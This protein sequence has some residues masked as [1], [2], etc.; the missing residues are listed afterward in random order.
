MVGSHPY[1]RAILRPIFSF[2][3]AIKV[4]QFFKYTLVILIYEFEITEIMIQSMNPKITVM[5]Y[6]INPKS[7]KGISLGKVEGCVINNKG[8]QIYNKENSYKGFLSND[9]KHMT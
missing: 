2:R 9:V 8:I 7:E 5:K 1:S 3:F 6:E 4:F